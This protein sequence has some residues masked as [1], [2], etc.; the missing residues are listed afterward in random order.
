MYPHEA[1]IDGRGRIWFNGHFTKTPEL[2]GYVDPASCEVRIFEVPVPPM[3]DGGSTIPYGLRAAPDGTIWMTELVGGRLVR[4]DP[5]TEAFDL[6]P[7][8]TPY[9][10][11]R[12]LDIAPDG[13]VWIPEFATN[14]LARF[15]PE[16]ETFTEYELPVSDALPY[17]ARVAPNG[18]VWVGTAGAD[19]VAR[20]DPALETFTLVPL[21]TPGSLIRHLDIDMRTGEVW[22]VTGDFPPRS[23]R[24]FRIRGLR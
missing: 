5:E 9:S 22:G 4:F 8:P 15:D 12:R 3:P 6:Y 19:L 17:V 14:R 11:P 1:A 24:V 23:P 18:S 7:L 13:T 2:L 16:T 10:G 21:P 20:F